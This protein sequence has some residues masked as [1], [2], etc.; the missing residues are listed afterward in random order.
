MGI[1]QFI[2]SKF[3]LRRFISTSA[4][5]FKQL[6]KSNIY[7]CEFN[8]M[9]EAGTLT[10]SQILF[11]NLWVLKKQRANT[12]STWRQPPNQ[13]HSLFLRHTMITW[14]FRCIPL[15]TFTYYTRIIEA[16]DGC[17][18]QN[19]ERTRDDRSTLAHTPNW[20]PNLSPPPP[21]WCSRHRHCRRRRRRHQSTA[22]T[23]TNTTSNAS[24]IL[25]SLSILYHRTLASTVTDR[26][27][28]RVNWFVPTSNTASLL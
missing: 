19:T 11:Y 25:Q 21:D 8:L 7:L 26:T 27:T 28:I 2:P 14:L 18:K 1:H 4:L 12:F 13:M 10:V 5:S 6:Q 22:T 15:N 17:S 9:S 24:V 20:A 3:P 16:Q 23:T